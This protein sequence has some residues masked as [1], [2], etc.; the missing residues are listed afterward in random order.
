M[1]SYT[2]VLYEEDGPI[3]RLTLNRPGHG[4]MFD[5]VML[6]EL[7]EVLTKTRRETRTRVVVITGAGDRFFCIGGE[8]SGLEPI[9]AYPGVLPVVDLYELIDKHPK[10]II[11]SVNGYAVGG[12]NVL[13]VVC[14]LSIAK[15]S[16]VFRQVGPTVGSFDAGFGTWY[17]EDLVGR[18]RAKEIW[19]LNEKLTAGQALAYGLVNRVVP[20]ADLRAETDRVALQI[21]QR[22]SQAI[23][24][25]KA[26]FA[27]RSQGVA[28]F[29]R[30]AH[31]QLLRYYSDS[32]EAKELAR[33]FEEKRD[34]DPGEFGR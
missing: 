9:H 31:D 33:A 14:D 21:T 11:A 2:T 28:G 5:A 17:L 8:K 12:G 25:V 23:A 3:G 18:K 16:A 20:D 15:E 10:P 26:S 30:V 13:Q 19:F 32:R 6:D 34:P 4:N 29:S 1:T 27:A 22:G 24:A 7:T